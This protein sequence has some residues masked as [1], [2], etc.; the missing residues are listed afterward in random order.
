MIPFG[1]RFGKVIISLVIWRD[2][3]FKRG[4]KKSFF[5]PDAELNFAENLL[6]G[7]ENRQ[8]ISFHGEGRESFSL[9]F[10]QLRENVASLAK[11]MKEV[12]VEKGDCIATLLPNCPETIIT[13]L[14][15]SS[16][17]LFSLL[18]HLTLVLKNLDRFGQSKP[19]ILISCDGYGYGGKILELRKKRLRLKS[20]FHQLMSWF[21]L[22]TLK[23]KRKIVYLGIIF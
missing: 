6:V 16:L 17:E 12:G 2:I 8:A 22:I 5:F 19:K 11:W 7:D 3:F 14:A 4:Y 1:E 9:T 13:M 20:L 23:I 21:L 18:A 10:K 15:A